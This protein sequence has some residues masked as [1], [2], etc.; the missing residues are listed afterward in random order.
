MFGG[1]QSIRDIVTV[2]EINAWYLCSCDSFLYLHEQISGEKSS[3]SSKGIMRSVLLHIVILNE[4]SIPADSL[5][6]YCYSLS[7]STEKHRI[8]NWILNDKTGVYTNANVI[9][10]SA[11]PIMIPFY[12]SQCDWKYYNV[13]FCCSFD[14]MLGLWKLK[15]SFEAMI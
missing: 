8:E 4:K 6:Y 1:H 11:S 2:F 14:C 15:Y 5:H 7:C 12:S 3:L 13:L 10:L 9:S